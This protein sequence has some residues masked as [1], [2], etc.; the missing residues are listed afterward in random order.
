MIR[1]T[2]I[3][4]ANGDHENPHL[5]ISHLGWQNTQTG[6]TGK[7]TRQQ[8]YDWLNNKGGQAYVTD[9]TGQAVTVTTATS[10]YGNPYV[11]T[12]SDGRETNNLLF[13]MEC[14]P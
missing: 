8:I 11:R 13:L 7:S 2:C 6:E 9:A 14:R 10:I 5:A 1:I 3:N 12:I 4:K